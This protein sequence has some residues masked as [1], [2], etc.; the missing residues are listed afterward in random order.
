MATVKGQNLRI[1]MDNGSGSLTAIAAAQQ[2]DLSV[3][4]GVKSISTK[5]DTGDFATMIALR[6]SWEVRA[7]GVVTADPTRNDQSTLMDRI[8][9][10]VHVQLALASG[11]KNSEM[12]DILLAGDAIISDVQITAPNDEESTYQVTLTGKKNMLT[13]IREII[14]ADHHNIRTADGHIVMAEHEQT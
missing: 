7:N 14:T 10:T 12:G 5:D 11:E 3:R 13:D 4:L 9:Q 1:F 6:L 8:G 2:C